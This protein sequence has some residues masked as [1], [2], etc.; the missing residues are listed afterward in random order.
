VN[1]A[2]LMALGAAFG[3]VAQTTVL[4]AV[5]M[6]LQSCAGGYHAKT[7]LNCF[8]IMVAVWFP[9]M[10]MMETLNGGTAIAAAAV[11][12][13]VVFALAPVRHVNVTMSARRAGTMRTRSR[14]IACASAAVSAA[15]ILS[16]PRFARLGIYIAAAMAT[17][18]LSMLAAYL[19]NR[20]Q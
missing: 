17:L 3:R 6:P 14:A 8:L 10:W 11:A 18:A 12:L 15:L 13:A 20:R 19:K 4:L 2:A 5:T 1:A 9:A 7:H 16:G